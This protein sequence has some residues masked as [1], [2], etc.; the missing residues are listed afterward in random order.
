MFKS[1][2]IFLRRKIVVR[3]A[4]THFCQCRRKIAVSRGILVSGLPLTRKFVFETNRFLIWLKSSSQRS[5]SAFP[6]GTKK[7]QHDSFRVYHLQQSL[8]L[9]QISFLFGPNQYSQ[10]STSA[11]PVGTKK[12][13]ISESTICFIFH[14]L[15]LEARLNSK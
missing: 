12:L 6:V 9:R 2:P 10:C 11:F 13:N 4:L 8:H 1:L 3:T 5:T 14:W 15:L 7:L